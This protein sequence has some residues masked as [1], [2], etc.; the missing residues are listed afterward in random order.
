M[1]QSPQKKDEE[2]RTA[3]AREWTRTTN[4]P[5]MNADL[6]RLRRGSKREKYNR[7]ALVCNQSRFTLHRLVLICVHLRL[8]CFF[9]RVHSPAFAVRFVPFPPP[10]FVVLS[11]PTNYE[12][13]Y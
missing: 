10:P 4:E 2:K 1:Y 12:T 8:T 7:P 5:Q 3:N 13:N 11:K 6:R 9:V